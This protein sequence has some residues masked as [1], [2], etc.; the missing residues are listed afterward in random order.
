MAKRRRA[1]FRFPGP[2]PAEALRYLDG[3]HLRPAFDFRDVSAQEHAAAFT[4]AKAM[5][6]DLLKDVRGA[7]REALAEGRTFEQF[8]KDL[9]PQL[10]KAGWWGRKEMTDPRTG[11]RREVRLG[12]PR[13]LRTIYRS[14][15]RAA[16]AAGQWERI[17]RTA[18]THPYLLYMR[19]SARERRQEH[20]AWV[21][22]L[23][24]ADDPWWDTHFTP[25]GWG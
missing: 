25:N 14:N 23:L 21:G 16:R 20:L 5:E 22:T 15:L 8:R 1:Q 7:V 12:S 6:L 10:R 24:P 11:E 3:K 18:R 9:E 19:S 17:R 13:R 2:R 4:V